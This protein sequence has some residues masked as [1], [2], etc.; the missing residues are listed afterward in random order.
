MIGP[1]RSINTGAAVEECR[2]NVLSRETPTPR[3]L[4]LNPQGVAASHTRGG[5]CSTLGGLLLFDTWA[6]SPIRFSNIWSVSQ[7][8]LRICGPSL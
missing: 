4:Q 5:Y 6:A 2:E 3:G 8:L 1:A 7:S